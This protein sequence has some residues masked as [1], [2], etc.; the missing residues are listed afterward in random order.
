M[1]QNVTSLS[2]YSQQHSFC[3]THLRSELRIID[4]TSTHVGTWG[5]CRKTMAMVW[6]RISNVNPP[7]VTSRGGLFSAVLIR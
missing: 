7:R 6:F 3:R 1:I 2:A 4:E 5:T